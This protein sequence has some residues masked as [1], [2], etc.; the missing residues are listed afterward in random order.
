[1]NGAELYL[2]LREHSIDRIEKSCQSINTGDK[3]VLDTSLRHLG[4]H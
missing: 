1:M 4:K 2:R 3:D